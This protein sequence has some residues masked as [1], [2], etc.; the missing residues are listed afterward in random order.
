MDQTEHT[1]GS[2][3]TLYSRLETE[4][5]PFL[6]RARDCARQTIPALVPPAGHSNSSALYKPFQSTGARS[7]NNLSSKL[8][9][10]LVPPTRAFFRLRLADKLMLELQPGEQSELEV[11]LT[12]MERRIMSEVE[13]LSIRPVLF[14]ALRQLVVAG[15][16]LI[17][18]DAD[19]ASV[20]S[21]EQFVVRRDHEGN[22]LNI[23]VKE[24]IDPEMLP[25]DVR[26]VI[27]PVPEDSANPK[28]VDLYTHVYREGKRW[29]VYQECR[30]VRFNEA[31]YG[32]RKC[33]WI[34]VRWTSVDRENYGRS[35]C[36]EYIGDLLA[37]EAMSRS[38]I[39]AAAI[40]AKVVFL[41]RPNGFT[42]AS[43]L[44][45][46]QEGDFID[47]QPEDITSV[48]VEKFHDFQYA[49]MVLDDIEKRLSF[50]FLLNSAVQRN[51]ERVTAE[52]IRYLAQELE[53]TLGGV[54]SVLTRELLYPLVEVVM[55]NMIA[56][57]KLP[58]LKGNVEP[59]IITGVD[60][61]G[62]SHELQRLDAFIG[63]ALQAFG[64][65]VL[66]YVN[67]SD[68]L[69]RRASGLDIDP[70]GLVKDEEQLAQEQQQAMA[71]QLAQKAAP[72]VAKG[73]VE[74]STGNLESSRTGAAMVNAG[75]D[76][77]APGYGTI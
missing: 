40:A 52:E 57:N 11:A 25:E 46:A 53:D 30:G 75:A 47:G 48:G 66:Q 74:A 33:P 16:T 54:W 20:F 69:R 39:R 6:Q 29:C 50:A 10:A 55:S 59:T 63:G 72:A 7:V 14:E 43:D 51:G 45:E 36:D 4:R 67:M 56:V 38:L 34:A 73:V 70:S 76:T 3:A 15:N 5:F 64:P 8:L 18:I 32:E 19:K 49:K 77:M 1:M 65:Q 26:E 17:H 23:V 24:Q 61:L 68:Y 28:C 71:A 22:M 42:R 2:A 13:R 9:L 58:P 41:V 12:N 35:H 21:F 44:Q 31:H 60:A 62:R 37:C 27:P